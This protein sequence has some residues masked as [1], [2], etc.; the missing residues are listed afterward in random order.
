MR[1]YEYYFKGTLGLLVLLKHY[2]L[3]PGKG[4]FVHLLK[5]PKITNI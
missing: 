1:T 5:G 2:I 4:G 3:L